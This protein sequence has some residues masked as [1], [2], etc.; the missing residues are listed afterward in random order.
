MSHSYSNPNSIPIDGN[1]NELNS[2]SHDS[3]L[4]TG[5]DETPLASVAV[6]RASQPIT[7]MLISLCIHLCL[8][9][10]MALILMGGSG[11]QGTSFE[12]FVDASQDSDRVDLTT[13]EFDSSL[14]Q[15]S[16]EQ[17]VTE[18]PEVR[19]SLT[20][21]QPAW[22]SNTKSDT[23]AA[24][25]QYLASGAAGTFSEAAVAAST[26]GSKANASEKNPGY[27][28]G[29]SFFGAY[30]PGQRFVFVIDSSKSMLEGTRW[31]RLRREL[32]RAI[33]SLS[34]DQEFFVVSFD[35]GM[36]PMFDLY[37]PNSSFLPPTDQ[38][39]RRLNSWLNQVQHGSATLPASSIGL[40]LKLQPD[41]IF[42]L[43]DGEIQDNTIQ[44][45]RFHNRMKDDSGKV[46]VAIP[47]HT[48]LLHS[49]I[50]AATLRII[51]DENDGVFTPVGA[52]T[53]QE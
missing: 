6:I 47:I 19:V 24:E 11:R 36:H 49:Q 31:S 20:T 53:R 22:L 50:G 51:A 3:E 45:L 35:V 18:T 13:I 10:G 27:G 44:E 29:A 43:S 4:N 14:S 40:A 7:A 17:L 28:Q 46:K 30:A 48:L 34:P 12:L 9:L 42:L 16:S 41:A 15:S 5:S 26:A 25:G 39:L 52:L 21:P 38:S 8:L 33:Q 23:L 1:A 32:I 37:P 2:A